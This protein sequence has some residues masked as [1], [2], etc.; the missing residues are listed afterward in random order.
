MTVLY[1]HFLDLKFFKHVSGMD[2]KPGGR[3]TTI[4]NKTLF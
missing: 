4:N 1:K 2:A 3:P